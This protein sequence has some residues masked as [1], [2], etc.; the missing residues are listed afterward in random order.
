[1][2][3]LEHDVGSR[4]GQ[5]ALVV[6]MADVMQKLIQVTVDVREAKNTFA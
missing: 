3:A 6:T 2:R 5:N 4:D 1:L